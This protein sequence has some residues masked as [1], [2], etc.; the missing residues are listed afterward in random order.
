M[1]VK[2]P[3]GSGGPYLVPGVGPVIGGEEFDWPD[4]QPPV[5][6]T[7]RDDGSPIVAPAEADD[8]GSK[9]EGGDGEKDSGDEAAS[10]RKASSGKG[11]AR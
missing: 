6:G 4:D 8:G 9:D 11:S 2:F 1:R 10:S 5:A 7:V 3:D